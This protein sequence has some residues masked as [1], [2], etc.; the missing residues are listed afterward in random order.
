MGLML[1][2]N[3]FV[4]EIKL[5]IKYA[6][7][8]ILCFRVARMYIDNKLYSVKAKKVPQ[9]KTCKFVRFYSLF[10]PARL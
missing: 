1:I 7:Y 5:H 10:Q 2:Q 3:N 8:Y 9:A 6:I 4:Y